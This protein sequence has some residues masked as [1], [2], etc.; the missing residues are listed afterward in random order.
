MDDDSPGEEETEAAISYEDGGGGGPPGGNWQLNASSIV[1]VVT[2]V[3]FG[4]SPAWEPPFAA[5]DPSPSQEGRPPAPCCPVYEG[6]VHQVLQELVRP[7]LWG[8]QT[9]TEGSAI[10]EAAATPH[11]QRAGDEDL[12]VGPRLTVQVGPLTLS[13][14]AACPRVC[15]GFN[16][17]WPASH[18]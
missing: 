3:L 12:P 14:R 9:H 4:A 8:V 18:V 5:T 17:D 10:P 16:I 13:Q 7:Q 1:V 6:L 2:E 15:A 11:H